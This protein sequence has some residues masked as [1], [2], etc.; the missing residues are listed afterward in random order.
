MDKLERNLQIAEVV[1]TWLA[2]MTVVIG[3]I[4]GIYEYIEHKSALT[5]DRAFDFVTNYQSNEFL[6][7]AR[8]DVSTTIE[9][10]LP[11][12]STILKNPNLSTEELDKAYHA[13]IMKIIKQNNITSSLE[14]L[15]IFYEQVLLCR[16]M[17]L[18][19]ESILENF[20]DNEAGT[21]IR[22]FY[23]YICSVRDKWNNPKAHQTI[24]SFYI[25]NAEGLCQS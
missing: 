22:T 5:V 3:F 2:A 9:Q 6:V 8:L 10:N 15:F 23:P 24:V 17:T 14:T 21:S 19:D 20:F 12:I 18:C 7:K 11:A 16:E 4:F 13:E 25:G 1:G